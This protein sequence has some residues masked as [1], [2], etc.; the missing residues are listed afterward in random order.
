MG[1]R[2]A[3]GEWTPVIRVGLKRVNLEERVLGDE[4][5][6]ASPFARLVGDDILR[7]LLAEANGRRF[8]GGARIFVEADRGDSLFFLLKGEARRTVGTGAAAID[9]AIVGKGELMG[10]GEAVGG[11][12]FRQYTATAAG[13]VELLEF[14]RAAIRILA[15]EHP[16]VAHYLR[17]LGDARKAAGAEMANFLNR[18]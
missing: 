5:L 10:E 8:A 16:E 2:D 11:N 17:K 3:N 9:V 1:E 6:R 4:E 14:P 18:W 7:I 15:R 13:D 12:A